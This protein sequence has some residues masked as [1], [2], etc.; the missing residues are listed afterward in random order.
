M[1]SERKSKVQHP[2]RAMRAWPPIPSCHYGR[3]V[4]HHVPSMSPGTPS[5]TRDQQH[6]SL[7]VPSMSPDTAIS[8]HSQQH[9]S[10]NVPR[11]SPGLASKH[12]SLKGPSMSPGTANSTYSQQRVSPKGTTRSPKCSH[13]VPGMSPDTL[14]SSSQDGQRLVSPNVVIMSPGTASSKRDQQHLSPTVPACPLTQSTT[15]AQQTQ[16]TTRVP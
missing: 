14:H 6:V 11:T 12:M 10:L 8:T 2:D 7:T 16:S 9:A 13:N 1:W 15:P 4:P 5:S 3:L